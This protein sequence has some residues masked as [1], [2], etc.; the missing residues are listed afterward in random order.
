MAMA[1]DMSKFSN[2]GDTWTYLVDWA[3]QQFT[4]EVAETTA[5]IM[6]TYGKLCARR[7][8]EDLSTQFGFSVAEY[9][10]A[11]ANM[12]EWL[13]LLAVATKT[14]DSLPDDATKTAFWEMVLHPVRAGKNVFEIYTNATLGQRYANEKR[15]ATNE[16]ADRARAAFEDDKALQKQ[17]HSI[18]GGKWNHMMDQ[19]H[20]GYNN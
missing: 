15:L 16:L 9:D 5:Q 6:T 7:K 2:P 13:D 14:H 12:Q 17:F 11:E 10:E 3:A 1:Y 20:I 18:L 8:Y 4:P 19:T